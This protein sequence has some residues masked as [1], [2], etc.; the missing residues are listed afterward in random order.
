MNPAIRVLLV[1]DHPVVRLGFRLLFDT[2]PDIRI[3]G[4]A[5]TGEQ[6]LAMY[7]EHQPDVVVMDL[8]MPGM[9]GLEAIRRLMAQD[10]RARVLALSAH[11]DVS[12]PRRALKARALGYLCK[13][14]AADALVPAVRELHAGRMVIDPLVAQRL[15]AASQDDEQPVM[16][17]LSEREYEAFLALAQG[18]SVAQVAEAMGVSAST[19]GTYLYNIKHKLGLANQSEMTLLAVREGL[20]QP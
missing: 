19:A 8:N 6:A 18:Q 20:I 7:A 4:E 14:G 15:Q 13:R 9:G 12:H 16:D 10:R 3:A 1:D 2:T 17:R 5:D 11:E